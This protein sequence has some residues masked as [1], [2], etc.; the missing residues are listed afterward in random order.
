MLTRNG[1]F[2][3]LLF[4]CIGVRFSYAETILPETL[5][6]EFAALITSGSLIT[7]VNG[8]PLRQLNPRKP[9][10]PAS[11][12]KIVT[13]LAAL[14]ILGPSYRFRTEIYRGDRN[15][16]YIKGFGDPFLTSESVAAIAAKIAALGITAISSITIDDSA[17][18]LT[19]S[20]GTTTTNPYDAPNSSIA[21]N[22]NSL[23]LIRKENG[24]IAPAEPQ[25]PFIPLMV[26]VGNKLKTGVHRV[27]IAAFQITGEP[28]I[29]LR[30]TAELFSAHLTN[31]GVKMENNFHVGPVP[32][33]AQLLYSHKSKPLTE[34]IHDCL[35]FSNNFIA[36]QLFLTCGAQLFGY[37][38]TWQKGRDALKTSLEKTYRIH[39]DNVFIS[40]GSGLS[41]KTMVTAVFMISVLE[42]FKPFAE[43]LTIKNKLRLK[44][45]SLNGVYCY[46]GYFSTENRLDPF[47]ILL[48][49]PQ[50]N[51]DKL[52]IKLLA[53]YNRKGHRD[54]L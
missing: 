6:P 33:Q 37:P 43:L 20:E 21:V 48:N 19:R 28:D 25:T 5:P 1:L 50:N 32:S 51:R 30:Y 42:S 31:A 24:R 41:R 2:T 9:F 15:D 36:N 13:A 44:S 17:F 14:D 34:I 18:A 4:T 8:R 10:I 46:A 16:L 38:A 53:D 54:G 29:C 39:T 40:E 45:G 7:T 26:R 11:T 49:Q 23:P 12:V 35:L 47:V 3:L 52:L 27:N 22:F